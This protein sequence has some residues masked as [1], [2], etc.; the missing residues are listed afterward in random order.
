ME[1]RCNLSLVDKFIKAEKDFLAKEFLSP[2]NKFSKIAHVKLNGITYSF[3]IKGHKD[4]GFGIFKPIDGNNA[5][6]VKDADFVIIQKYLSILPKIIA[7]LSFETE[8]GW[9]CNPF[10]YESASKSFG[11]NECFLVKNVNDC[12]RFDVITARFDGKN[13]WYDNSFDGYDMRLS[14]SLRDNFKHDLSQK[15]MFENINDISGITPEM[16]DTFTIALRS[17]DEFKK[18]STQAQLEKFLKAGGSKL[19][20]YIVRGSNIEM[21]WKSKSGAKYNS[22][23]K[24]D[25]FDVVSVGICVSSQDSKFHIKDLP[26]VIHKAE[27]ERG[28]VRGER[29]RNLF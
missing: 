20:S 22:L 16:I 29:N 24:K 13:F 11:I 27:D 14:S 21:I 25:T 3:N 1:V 17:W 5:E 12:Q 9:I 6:F 18:L 7:I 28:V 15:K 2:Y 8:H 23:I 19:Q 26:Y 4:N 10:N